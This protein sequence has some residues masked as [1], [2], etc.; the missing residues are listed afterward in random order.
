MHGRASGVLLH[1]TS[2]PSHCGIGD[3]GPGAYAFADF[4][5]HTRQRYWQML[6]LNPVAPMRHYSP[7]SSTSTFAGNPLL[8]NPEKMIEC[9]QLK[10][11]SLRNIP[12][13]RHDKVEYDMAL[14][15]KEYL[16]DCMYDFAHRKIIESY[17]YQS[18]CARNDHWLDDFTLFVA[19]KKSFGGQTWNRWP[20]EFRNRVPSALDAARKLHK[21]V[22]E[23]E[24]IL[25]FIFYNQWHQLR[26]YCN[27]RGIQIIGDIPIYTNYDSADTWAHPD[28][29]DLDE[30]RE[31]AFLSGVPPD[32]FSATGQ[33]WGNPVYNW[34]MMRETRYSWWIRRLE[35]TFSLYD[36]VRIDHFR[37]LIAYW[38]VAA[39]EKTAING[40]WMPVP[41]DDF[42][43]VLFRRFVNLPIIVEDLGTITADVR[44][45]IARFGFPGMK[46]LLFA[47]EKDDPANP[48][49]P[50]NYRP[51][52]VA[53]TGTHDTNTIR[54]W[55]EN[56]LDEEQ[57]CRL[58]NYI[59]KD[60]SPEQ[61]H[62]E[63]IRLVMMSVADKAI[64][65]IQDI[66]GLGE[67]TRM[68]RPSTAR[69]NWEWR[70]SPAFMTPERA[71]TLLEMTETYG[72]T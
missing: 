49:L 48:Y 50:H 17:D 14:E 8:I 51:N 38:R 40:E 37:G 10:R 3:L 24:K 57:R 1:I 32:Y 41:S 11:S 27:T 44:E 62:W 26:D 25:Q 9:G 54:G 22:I 52:C 66:F 70:L 71:E 55:F 65:P 47:F 7:Y 5:V 23:R 35:Q 21:R 46:L 33:L 16:F 30:N 28:L 4:L 67:E 13:F 31:R 2:L 29:F 68:N 45:A 36:I 56:E 63:M 12:E 18:F 43:N 59:G 6:P 64:F 39:G 53:Y 60:V 61:L 69:G 19:L 20:T 42:F 58:F 15:V 72:R 34:E